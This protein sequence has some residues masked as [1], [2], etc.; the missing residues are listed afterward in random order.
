M[1][2]TK[3]PG[4]G[5]EG[6]LPN[7]KINTRLVCPKCLK[8]FHVTT[9]GRSAAGEPPTPSAAATSKRGGKDSDEAQRFEDALRDLSETLTSRKALS[10]LGTILVVGLIVWFFAT[11]RSERVEPRAE[12][13]MKALVA[14][15]LK[16]LEGLCSTG[17]AQEAVKW[18]DKIRDV[19]DSVR[20]SQG[21]GQLVISVGVTQEDKA[22]G[23]A[24]VIAMAFLGEASLERKAGSLPDP[25]VALPV[26]RSLSIPMAFRSE[27]WSG[28]RLD[29]RRTLMMPTPGGR[30][31]PSPPR[32]Q[33]RR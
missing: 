32:G 1:I 24:D 31:A 20:Q 15:D 11:R 17:T 14:G 12:E 8:V 25:N 28:W 3:C 19:C 10:V 13:V 7:T 2:D 5:A 22:E 33:M 6:R 27:G 21:P 26:A 18:Y 9:A 4:C 30:S 23:T 16:T 29:G